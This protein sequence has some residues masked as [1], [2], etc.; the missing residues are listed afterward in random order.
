ME[1]ATLISTGE[2][3]VRIDVQG[4]WGSIKGSVRLPFR[5][6]INPHVDAVREQNI[7]WAI[8]VGLADADD[9]QLIDSID[10]CQFEQLAALC[11]RDCSLEALQLIT[12]CYTAIFVFDDM[13][14][15]ARS[16]IGS[17]EALAEHV[18]AYLSAA[19]ADE[20]RPELRDDIPARTRIVAVA[21]AYADVARRLLRYTERAGLRHYVD[22]M[23]NY[24]LGCVMESRKRNKRMMHVA[25][26][27]I[28]RLRCSAV[29][30]T[31]DIGAIVE[32][33]DVSDEVREDPAFQTMRSATNLC[34]SYINDLFSYA[35]ESSAG[36][37][38]NLVT[39]Y[40]TAY[41]MNLH[42]AME[43]AMKTNDRVIEEYFEAKAYFQQSNEIDDATRGY[44]KIME[45]W[46]R[47]NFDWYHQRR[48][49]R[50]EHY[51]ATAIPA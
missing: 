46:M 36:E 21:N 45:D 17:N 26:Y 5:S 9:D 3:R 35:K 2:R 13:L 22:G 43:A 44:I 4:P 11:H 38:S 47:G 32:R 42:R 19:V 39:V 16:E 7:A 34:V 8:E 49:E 20:P 12:N 10:R 29:Y 37:F 31:L 30:P 28:V 18:T 27:T 15:D 6:G 1:T 40:Q 50:Y 24:F 25:D 33:F 51:L 48:T 14:D 23:R 41:G